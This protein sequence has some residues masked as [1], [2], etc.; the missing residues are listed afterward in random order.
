MGCTSYKAVR[1]EVA[2]NKVL[3]DK[4]RIVTI[5][6]KEYILS[7]VL[8]GENEVKGILDP[9]HSDWLKDIQGEEIV[10]LK[11]EI[12]EIEIEKFEAGLTVLTIIIIIG[13]P[14]GLVI[15]GLSQMD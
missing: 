6:D 2:E 15:Y 12:K 5:D 1:M 4:A 10:I 7:D 3:I 14:L 8:V 11:S 9:S 13:V